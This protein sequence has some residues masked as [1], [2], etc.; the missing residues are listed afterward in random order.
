MSLKTEPPS[1]PIREHAQ[2]HVHV[3]LADDDASVARAMRRVLSSAGLEVTSVADGIQAAD[4]LMKGNYDVVVSDI[5]MPNMTGVELLSLVRA[6]D[7]DVPVI[8]LT[9]DPS[10]ETAV[11]ALKLG[12]LEYMSKPW[13]NQQLIAAIMRAHKLHALARLKRE[14]LKLMGERGAEAGD[15]AGL[16]V[17]F[18]RAL[19]TVYVAYQPIVSWRS[20]SVFAYECLLRSKDHGLPTTSSVL[21]AGDRLGREHDIGRRIRA[22][23]AREVVANP[24]PRDVLVF[25][26]IHPKDLLDDELFS[27]E[28]PLAQ[29]SSRVV[30]ELTERAAISGI[31]DVRRRISDLRKRGFRIALDDL[32]AGYAGLSSFAILEPDF[33]KLDM[34]LVQ[35]LAASPVR[36]KLVSS[37][38]TTCRELGMRV[39]AE[40]IESE[41][42]RVLLSE[43]GCDLMQGFLFARPGLA[44]PDPTWGGG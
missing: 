14:A 22:L 20:K 19:E 9:G 23:V 42:D 34:S 37:M 40:G 3:L 16:S 41:N 6:Y 5:R 11:E 31:D 13:D 21:D 4:A 36:Q 43:L 39:V 28:S 30:L 1:T 18:E 38:A 2:E 24:P 44:Y 25:L 35:D 33:V 12:A 7:L 26:N 15:L 29:I 17:S 27:V 8:L 32:G 10:L